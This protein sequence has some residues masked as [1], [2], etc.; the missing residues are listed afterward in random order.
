MAAE[1]IGMLKARGVHKFD[2]IDGLILTIPVSYGRKTLSDD[3]AHVVDDI[4]VL[5]RRYIKFYK[6]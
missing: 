6:L 2:E 1:K 4:S 3:E 5:K